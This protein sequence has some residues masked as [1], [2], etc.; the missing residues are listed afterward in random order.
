[1]LKLQNIHRK[2]G[3]TPII[4]GID[5]TIQSGQV[6]GLVGPNGCG[7]TS[8][9]NL[10]NG[11]YSPTEGKIIHDHLDITNTSVE[12]RAIGGIGRVFQS[13]GIF[14]NLTLYENL[15]LAFVK[16]LHRKYKFLPI[17]FLPKHMRA[18]I[19]E[20]LHELELYD[21][22]DQLAGNLSGGQMRL[23]EIGRLYLQKTKVYLLD[24]PTA[25]VSPKLKGKVI[26]LIN[27]IIS[28]DRMVIIVEH[29]F[30][31]LAQFVDSFCVMNEGKIVLEGNYS[32]IKHS[33][34]IKEIYFGKD[35]IENTEHIL[36]R[37]QLV[38]EVK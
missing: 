6:I 17:R 31:F 28:K 21:K 36:E 5:F 33:E 16:Q 9:L 32:Q 13:F 8:L 15:A 24:E 35:R 20:I 34:V 2:A 26:D 23:L 22:K 14:R 27:K 3:K 19:D 11:F 1:M 29:D 30:E 12:Q 7:K 10:I 4:N 18:E 25:G 37:G 38:K